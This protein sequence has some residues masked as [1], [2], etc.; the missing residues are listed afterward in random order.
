MSIEALTPT[1]ELF[2]EWKRRRHDYATRYS[3]PERDQILF[4]R[5]Q[6]LAEQAVLCISHFD[7]ALSEHDDWRATPLKQVTVTQ[8]FCNW[9]QG[10]TRESLVAAVLQ[11][12]E[13]SDLARTFAAACRKYGYR[14]VYFKVVEESEQD[15]ADFAATL[16]KMSTA[17]CRRRY[18]GI[19]EPNRTGKQ[20]F[21][22]WMDLLERQRL[23]NEEAPR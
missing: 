16:S 21:K 18:M 4:D 17:E 13:R 1:Q 5:A 10:Q 22:Y 19:G 23:Y 2:M 11:A 9:I 14:P 6:D 3:T 8:E 20:S 15:L 7:L 12:G